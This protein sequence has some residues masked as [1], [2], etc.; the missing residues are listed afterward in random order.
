MFLRQ[1]FFI[2]NNSCSRTLSLRSTIGR[3]V[4]KVLFRVSRDCRRSEPKGVINDAFQLNGPAINFGFKNTENFC[5]STGRIDMKKFL[6]GKQQIREEENKKRK[7]HVHHLPFHFN[8]F[9]PL[10]IQR[11]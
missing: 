2:E 3:D 8:L 4:E 1:A 9:G 11:L 7:S 6:R 10:G 5:R